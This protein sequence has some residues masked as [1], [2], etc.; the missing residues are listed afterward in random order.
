TETTYGVV[1][2]AANGGAPGSLLSGLISAARQRFAEAALENVG[3]APGVWRAAA[4]EPANWTSPEAIGFRTVT[5]EPV[6]MRIS[7]LP[8][9]FQRIGVD[10]LHAPW[11]LRLGGVPQRL[12]LASIV[13]RIEVDLLEVA[14]GRDWLDLTLLGTQ[15]WAL[16]G[17]KAGYVS[18]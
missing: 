10:G 13:S 5:V 3:G 14:I 18:S 11:R 8:A 1:L 12:S 15:G 4:V 17:Q 2:E 16:G 6:T 9:E 7:R